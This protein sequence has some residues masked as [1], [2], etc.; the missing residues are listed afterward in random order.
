MIVDPLLPAPTELLG[1]GSFQFRIAPKRRAFLVRDGDVD[2]LRSALY[3][4]AALW[5]G[6]RCPIL[7]VTQAGEVQ[8]AFLQIAE[9]L[10]VVEAIDFTADGAGGASAWTVRD[11]SGLATVGAKPLEDARF[12][13]A[14]PLIGTYDERVREIYLPATDSLMALAGGGKYGLDEELP[15]F[16]QAGF[17]IVEGCSAGILANAQLTERTALGATLAFDTD[18]GIRGGHLAS[19]G[20]LWLTRDEDSFDDAVWF[21]NARAVRPRYRHPLPQAVMTTPEVART[22][23]FA[24]QLLDG[25][26]QSSAST[27]TFVIASLTVP[28]EELAE[29][30]RSFGAAQ[31]TDSKTSERL[32]GRQPGTEF[33]PSFAV[34]LDPI[35]YW[36]VPRSTGYPTSSLVPLQRPTVSMQLRSPREWVPE[37]LM[38]GRVTATISSPSIA[39]PQKPA[40]AKLYHPDAAW[41]AGDGIRIQTSNLQDYNLS[42]TLPQPGAVLAASVSEQGYEYELSDKG[43]QIRGALAAQGDID[44]YRLRATVHAVTLLTAKAGRDL[45]RELKRLREKDDVTQESIERLRVASLLGHRPPRTL[46]DLRSGAAAAGGATELPAAVE[47]LV[48]RG[49]A[50][51]G[52][53]VDCSLCSLTGF[54]TLASIVGGAHCNGCGSP[55]CYRLD[56]R[57][58]PEVHFVLNSLMHTLSLN[59]GLAP[60]AATALLTSE[61]FYV[62]PGVNLLRNGARQAELDILGWRDSTCLAGEAKMSADG[63]DRADI[64][65]D[66][67]LAA[68]AGA[69]TFLA[70]SVEALSGAT[71]DRLEGACRASKLALRVI[72]GPVLL[73]D[74]PRP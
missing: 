48:A 25:L 17:N 55:A 29:I 33:S 73:L 15:L 61:G 43:Q 39:G 23:E 11:G 26:R 41:S 53:L 37:Y 6:A 1:H 49:A 20:V 52:L 44:F 70:V 12:W 30:A 65:R 40:V 74:G 3:A 2:E 54:Q 19:M 38:S 51:M 66:V 67:E 4:A 9:A 58:A 42:L 31:H 60:L 69:D 64:D 71:R 57:G 36:L 62:E 5:G 50:S 24:S 47:E 7:P 18:T 21:W 35:E 14:H 10:D 63:F 27:P 22:P 28:D 13:N 46:A 8:P 16:R 68:R 34:N 72:D 59:G 56:Q 45:A 32:M